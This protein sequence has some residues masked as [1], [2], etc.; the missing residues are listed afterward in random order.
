MAQIDAGSSIKV[1]R[2]TTGW[3]WNVSVVASDNSIDELR[4]ARD[5][6]LELDQDLREV[7]LP[8]QVEVEAD[9]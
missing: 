6:A 2:T 4:E 9:F 1:N 3:T 8:K 5:K 7:L